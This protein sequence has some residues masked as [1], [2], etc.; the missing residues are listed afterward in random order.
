MSLK[1]G[2]EI[3]IQIPPPPSSH[4]PM[5][6]A[7][8]QKFS[9][10]PLDL[11]FKAKKFRPA[12][13]RDHRGTQGGGVPPPPPPPFRP[14]L[15]I[16][17]CCAPRPSFH[18]SRPLRPFFCTR[19]TPPEPTPFPH[20]PNP[21]PCFALQGLRRLWGFRRL[22]AKLARRKS[23]SKMGRTRFWKRSLCPPDGA[24]AT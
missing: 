20:S 13:S 18:A 17:P 9:S 8:S 21:V 1:I 5:F 16:H 14:P 23:S 11:G 2:P 15:I 24:H 10:P 22:T 19:C 3:Q 12:L 4:L 6:E 7:D